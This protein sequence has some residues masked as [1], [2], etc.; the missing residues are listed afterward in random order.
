MKLVE[1]RRG[2][3]WLSSKEMQKHLKVSGCELM[4]Q[5]EVGKLTFR[6]KGNAYFYLVSEVISEDTLNGA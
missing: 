2:A 6:K 4:H 5:R 3:I 1:Q